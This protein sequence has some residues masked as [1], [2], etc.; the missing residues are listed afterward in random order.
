MQV[1]SAVAA[2]KRAVTSKSY[3]YYVE[4][5]FV[6]AYEEA[7]HDLYAAPSGHEDAAER[8]PIVEDPH[9]G[10]V[11]QG[12]RLKIADSADEARAHHSDGAARR[13]VHDTDVGNVQEHAAAYFSVAVYQYW[14]STSAAADDRVLVSRMR[15]VCAPGAERMVMDPALLRIR[16]GPTLNQSLVSFC[17]T[18]QVS[19]LPRPTSAPRR[20]LPQRVGGG[21][22]I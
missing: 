9:E 12:A 19:A 15:F 11:L 5:S 6:E 7:V 1:G 21:P 22:C 14:P 20:A 4:T 18:L 8:L 17:D 3:A 16:E 10:W 13:W 2:N